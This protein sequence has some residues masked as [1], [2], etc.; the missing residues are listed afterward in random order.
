M[1]AS[2]HIG[3][4][5]LWVK[6]KECCPRIIKVCVMHWMWFD[7]MLSDVYSLHQRAVD[8]RNLPISQQD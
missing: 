8:W 5:A 1:T 4:A 7:V 3:L 2:V 6:Y